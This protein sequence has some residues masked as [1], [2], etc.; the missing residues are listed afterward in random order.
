[1]CSRGIQ[2]K[3]TKAKRQTHFGSEEHIVL[4]ERENSYRGEQRKVEWGSGDR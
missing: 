2:G 4:Q 3:V 1:M